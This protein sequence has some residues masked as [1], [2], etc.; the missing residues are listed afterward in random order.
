MP[1]GGWHRVG[2]W[3]EAPLAGTAQG[4]RIAAEGGDG[5][6]RRDNERAQ[7]VNLRANADFNAG[8]NLDG[9]RAFSDAVD[10]EADDEIVQ[11]HGQGQE[12]AAENGGGDQGKGDIAQHARATRPNPAP[13]RT[14]RRPCPPDGF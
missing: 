2:T 10:E 5:E 8:I 14:R 11:G 7:R 6:H 4:A 3:V 1:R 9:Q 13:R 12:S